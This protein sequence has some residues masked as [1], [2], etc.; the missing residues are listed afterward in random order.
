MRPK[1][2]VFTVLLYIF[3]YKRLVQ[4]ANSAFEEYQRC[5]GNL[6]SQED[7]IANICDDILIA[8]KTEEEHDK[9]LRKC[10]TILRDNN[11]TLNEKKC[12]WKQPEINF[13]GHNISAQGI[14]PTTY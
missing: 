14:K 1:I 2:S 13:Y 12:V 4:G 7:L 8:G 10:L 9:N 3:R 5:I 11:L 6:F